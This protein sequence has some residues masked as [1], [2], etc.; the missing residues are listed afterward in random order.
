[1]TTT[2]VRTRIAPSPTGY[3]HIGTIYQAWLDYAFTKKRN[4]QFIIR[5]E[6]TDQKRLVAD[7]E[8]KLYQALDWFGIVEDESPRKDGPYRPYRQSERLPIYQR[9]A[10]KLVDSGHAY[11]CFCSSERLA[12][13]RKIQQK[14]GQPPMYDRHCLHLSSAEINRRKKAGQKYVIRL[15]VPRQE[16]IV[17]TDLIRGQIEFQGRTI[18]D[19][20]LIKS[21]GFPTYHLA[22]VVDDH[23][24]KISH[25]VRGE[26]WLPS[27]PKHELIY[28]YLGW[29]PAIYVHHPTLRNP[30]KSKLSKRHGHA[31][32]DWYRQ[33]GYLPDA[34]LNYFAQ[35]GW[36][37]P[38]GKDIISRAEFIELFD[39]KDLSVVGPVFDLAKLN[40]LNGQ[41]IRAVD[42]ITLLI[43]LK[44]FRQKGMT[45]QK[46]KQI[47][48]LVKQRL[49][50][51]SDWPDLTDFFIHSYSFFTKLIHS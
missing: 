49:V 39:F 15:K 12:E 9:Y 6:D 24:M 10:D 17:V 5:I 1:M 26:E 32:V 45:T 2:P 31:A 7:A 19:Q 38:E 22:V 50:V 23:L 44:P 51:L 47:L 29:Q 25:I 36:S 40:W 16:T 37:H 30:D 33:Q 21:D 48:P 46:A 20:V 4:G 3:P 14:Q 18:D 34:I 43:L 35:L 28:R 13:N 42:D 41:Y 11:L 8:T 27:S